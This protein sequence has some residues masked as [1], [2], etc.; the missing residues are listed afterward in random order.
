MLVWL[1]FIARRRKNDGQIKNMQ[2]NQN[3]QNG[4][5]RNA[6]ERGYTRWDGGIENHAGDRQTVLKRLLARD[7][8]FAQYIGRRF[9][10]PLLTN[11]GLALS[12]AQSHGDNC[13]ISVIL[14]SARH[15]SL[16]QPQ[17]NINGVRVWLLYRGPSPFEARLKKSS[18]L[19][20]ENVSAK[21]SAAPL[22]QST[23]N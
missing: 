21:S 19:V 5:K 4:G 10:G 16:E 2:E 23:T 3:S 13:V 7:Y 17:T 6:T 11:T 9:C 12:T 18:P 8:G 20:T 1:T 14:G 22:S 15:G